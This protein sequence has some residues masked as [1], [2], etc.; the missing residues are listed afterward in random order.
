[1]P[2]IENQQFIRLALQLKLYIR[3]HNNDIFEIKILDDDG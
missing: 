1:M 2:I 3:S